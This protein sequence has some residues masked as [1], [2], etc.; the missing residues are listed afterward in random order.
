MCLVF[1][2]TYI[3]RRI[4]LRE[5]A[6]YTLY[7]NKFAPHYILCRC[8]GG[9]ADEVVTVALEAT[10]ELTEEERRGDGYIEGFGMGVLSWIGRDRDA[11][12]DVR[13]QIG[14]DALTFVAHDE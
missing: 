12:I 11:A 7:A 8:S 9:Q 4:P 14:V 2:T 6:F 13:L 1:K 3:D 5:G 10:A